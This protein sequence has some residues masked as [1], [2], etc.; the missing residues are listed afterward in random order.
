MGNLDRPYRLWNNCK[1]PGNP[2]YT[3]GPLS[4]CLVLISILDYR[5]YKHVP[6]HYCHTSFCNNESEYIPPPPLLAIMFVKSC[7]LFSLFFETTMYSNVWE[8]WPDTLELITWP[9]ILQNRCYMCIQWTRVLYSVV[10][11]WQSDPPISQFNSPCN[12]LTS[13]WS[14][15][16]YNI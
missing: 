12:E 2:F 6:E 1:I 13:V 14:M 7:N 9:N 11:T 3:Q 15:F 10:I 4:C 8:H 5:K 16:V